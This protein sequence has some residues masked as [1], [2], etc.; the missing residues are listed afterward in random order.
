M[1]T[2][3]EIPGITHGFFTREGGHST[4]LFASLNTGFGS[5]DD[6]TIVTQNRDVV[7]RALKAGSLMTVHQFHSADVHVAR[8]PWDMLA[9]PKAD[10]MV[11]AV[12][13]LALGILTADCGP[14]LFADPAAR[15]VGV[16]HAGWKGALTGVT[17]ATIAAMETLGARRASITAVLGP[18]ISRTAYE[19]GP[20]FI[21]RFDDRSFFSPSPREGHF[22]FDLPGYIT[23]RLRR[24]GIGRIED[25]ALCTYAD[26]RRFFSFRR[27]THRKEPDYGRQ[28]SCI[29][30]ETT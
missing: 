11:T 17:D 28:I 30:L 13:G 23:M 6:K 15:I 25:T 8:E 24:A 21:D 3:T 26:E 2:A 27:T 19:T 22:M 7:R 14:I 29:V 16:A 4:G 10:A 20:E 12:P 9:P 5:G 1:I 18:M